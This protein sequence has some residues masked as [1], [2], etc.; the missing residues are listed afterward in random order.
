[1]QLMQMEFKIYSSIWNWKISR[2][3][4][5]K[6]EIPNL[7]GIP[8]E[9]PLINHKL[10][11]NILKI[12]LDIELARP[13]GHSST[14]LNCLNRDEIVVELL[15]YPNQE[16]YLPNKRRF[17]LADSKAPY[18]FILQEQKTGTKWQKQQKGNETERKRYKLNRN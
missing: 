17:T 6:P 10:S 15:K 8:H 1:M 14:V 2:K 12:E 7:Q 4:N 3:S 9:E 5:L 16:Q 11:I 13:L 18:L